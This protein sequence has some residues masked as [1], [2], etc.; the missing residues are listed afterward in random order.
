MGGRLTVDALSKELIGLRKEILQSEP[1]SNKGS[2]GAVRDKG[3]VLFTASQR[4]EEPSGCSNTRRAF[5]LLVTHF[6]CTGTF[7]PGKGVTFMGR[8]LHRAPD[9][10]TF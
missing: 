10:E 3:S 2:K 9:T 4:A 7:T 8:V 1:S 5:H 6:S